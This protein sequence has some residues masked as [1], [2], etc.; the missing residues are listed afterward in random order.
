[1]N[2]LDWF[3]VGYAIAHSNTTCSWDLRV[4]AGTHMEMVGMGLNYV[5]LDESQF[6]QKGRNIKMFRL[7]VPD[8][9]LYSLR[10]VHTNNVVEL[11]LTLHQSSNTSFFGKTLS[12][13]FPNVEKLY[14]N[15]NLLPVLD[16]V[17]VLPQLKL[18]SELEIVSE[19]YSSSGTPVLSGSL[20]V[21]VIN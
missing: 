19:S 11:Y 21:D 17:A 8:N 2:S 16:I 6:E 12:T 13:Y 5:P 20:D 15:G 18:L 14:I 1:M 7:D 10:P 4:I 9:I 3:V